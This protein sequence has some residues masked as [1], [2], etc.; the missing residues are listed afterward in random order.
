[1]TQNST[2]SENLW[3]PGRRLRNEQVRF[4]PSRDKNL[5]RPDEF[6]HPPSLSCLEGAVVKNGADKLGSTS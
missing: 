4:L 2:E 1:M 3:D 5:S 6:Q